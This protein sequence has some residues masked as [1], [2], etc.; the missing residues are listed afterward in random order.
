[1]QLDLI[2]QM[3][4][5]NVRRLRDDIWG[6]ADERQRSCGDDARSGKGPTDASVA[7][8]NG[9]AAAD[10]G[11]GRTTVTASDGGN[12]SVPRESTDDLLLELDGYIGLSEVKREVRSLVNMA[13]V[14]KMRRESDLPTAD[15]SL[16][17]VFSG[18]P[19]TGKTMIARFMSRIYHSIGLLSKGHLV[20]TDRSALVAGYVGQTAAKTAAVLNSALGGVLFIDEAYS[21]T[22]GS[23]ND[24]G[25]ECID[26]VLKF[27]E[28]HRDDI[29]VIVAGYTDLMERFIDSN[30][31][32]RSRFNKYIEFDDYTGEEMAEIFRH[33]CRRSSYE[34]TEDAMRE[35]T[36]YFDL[37]ATAP[38][39]FG[40]ARGV[41][42]VFERVLSAQADRLA[43]RENVTREEL[44]RLEAS[45]VT[46]AIRPSD[47]DS[48]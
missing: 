23:E 26:T 40:N 5:Q 17:M 9:A 43:T 36:G 30:P 48:E 16:H 39:E 44:M 28:D 1:M 25:G 4:E 32:L 6:G 20:E 42:N 15:M 24:F 3:T 31:G 19:G 41:R 21:L 27:M 33:Q 38:A 8:N 2:R 10:V 7:P 37:A 46:C 34:P 45:D 18:N 12:G 14:L 29:V 22:G 47:T 13:K 35:I 11:D